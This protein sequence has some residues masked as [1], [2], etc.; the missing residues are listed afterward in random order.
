ME[1]ARFDKA[2]SPPGKHP[3]VLHLDLKH[4]NGGYYPWYGRVYADRNLVLLG[5]PPHQSEGQRYPTLKVADWGLA[6]LTSVEHRKKN[7]EEWKYYGTII[8][9]PPVRVPEPLGNQILTQHTSHRS[10]EGAENMDGI[11]NMTSLEVPTTLS[12]WLTQSGK[13]EATCTDY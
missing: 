5:D 8:W 1:R 2:L 12:P 10:K 4:E 11:G 6:E 3:F 13:W 9:M 7:S